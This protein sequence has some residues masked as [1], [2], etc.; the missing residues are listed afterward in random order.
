MNNG[1]FGENFP[2]SNF[3][4]LNMDW[5]IKIAKDFLDQ[6]THIQQIISDG[7]TN[8]S[9]LT[10]EGL[11]QLQEKADALKEL[12][13]EW[14]NEHSNDISEELANALANIQTT[15][16]DALAN[17]ISTF[18]TQATTKGIEVIE[19]IPDDYTELS[20]AVTELINLFFGI[21]KTYYATVEGEYVSYTDGNAYTY[22][23]YNSTSYIPVPKHITT[24]F[25][26]NSGAGC[27]FYDANKNFISGTS[28]YQNIEIPSNAVYFRISD[29]TNGQANNRTV[30][31]SYDY[32]LEQI[33]EIVLSNRTNIV[34]I[35]LTETHS[36]EFDNKYLVKTDGTLADG[37]NYKTSDFI[38]IA[39]NARII[40]SNF[41]MSSDACAVA[42]YDNNKTFISS[43]SDMPCI[44]PNNARYM[45]FC[46]E[47]NKGA[48]QI[49]IMCN[50]NDLL[51]SVETF[52]CNAISGYFEYSNGQYYNHAKYMVSDYIPCP[53]RVTTTCVQGGSNACIMFYDEQLNVVYRTKNYSNI[54][55]P[56][57]AK[58]M[59]FSNFIGDNNENINA[60]ITC[61]YNGYK[62]ENQY[63]PLYGKKI[64]F[65]G[66]SLTH[67]DYKDP[68]EAYPALIGARNNATAINLG[69]S[70]SSVADAGVDRSPMVNRVDTIPTD[71]NYIMLMG[72]ANDYN[73]NVPIGNYGSDDK[74][75]FYGA[76]MYIVDYINNNIP[77]AKILFATTWRRTADKSDEVY[78]DAM[79][80]FCKKANIPC[81]DMYHESNIHMFNINWMTVFGAW[82]YSG[83]SSTIMTN[84]HLNA[85]G[86]MFISTQI[87]AKLKSI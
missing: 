17:A 34:N 71:S 9:N 30:V 33:P 87:E 82:T 21:P 39:P 11:E 4:D 75:T 74:T 66:D 15:L 55:I 63:N 26:Q 60:T 41:I 53:D 50:A 52:T 86:D 79:I 1:A 67:G 32:S 78:A 62:A 38:V 85:K 76:M 84:R 61:Y 81:L 28:D 48:T 45:K 80:D 83:D 16:T 57:Q 12:L 14:Y 5:I 77:E 13:Q 27:A 46:C 29:Y 70:G 51:G 23:G 73:A 31:C 18:N 2:Y 25:V 72:G 58:Y 19:S 49:K 56:T 7:E 43:T 6:Y 37:P 59:R 64:S 42:F 65:M 68:W 47:K 24:N 3:H 35:K 22:S 20:N 40:R 8:I 69:I 54:Y 44:A 10:T 36:P